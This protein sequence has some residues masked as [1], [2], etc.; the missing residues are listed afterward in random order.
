MKQT[1]NDGEREDLRQKRTK[2][3]LV[4]ALL[5]LM[6][7]RPFQELSVV[8]IC[9]RAMV[10]RTTFYAHFEDKHALL[11][12]A[13][14]ELQREFESVG[15]ERRDFPSQRAYFLAV[16]RNAL[17]FLRV[18]RRLYLSGM[19]GGGGELRL[20]EDA[21]SARLVEAADSDAPDPELTAR[22]YTGGI[23]AMLRWWLEQDEMVD[24]TRLTSCLEWLLPEKG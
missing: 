5:E 7:E 17:A 11:R 24:E 1:R 2:K 3:F 18:H 22:F 12:Y 15:G 23:L 19:A 20:L 6:E 14:G 8:D 13:I 21:V 4:N 9:Q 16:F 10:H